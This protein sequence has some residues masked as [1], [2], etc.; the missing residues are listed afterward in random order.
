MRGLNSAL[1]R[2]CLRKNDIFYLFTIMLLGI[3]IRI[4]FIFKVINYP[5]SDFYV[6]Q[7]IA[8]NIFLHKGHTYLGQPIAFQPMGYPTAL[9]Y[10]YRLLGSNN[11]FF[12]KVF[13][14][15]LSILTLIVLLLLLLKLVHTRLSIYLSYIMIIFI[16]NYIAYNNVLGSEILITLLFSI[17]IYLQVCSF[18]ATIR[19]TLI[20]LF[21]GIAALTKPF[22]LVYPFILAV[23]EWLHYKN[24]KNSLKTIS[25]CFI[26]LCLVVSPWTYRNY[27]K[28]KL[29]IPISYNGGY[30]LFINNNENNTSG[31]WMPLSSID[32]SENVKFKFLKVGL[33]YGFPDKNEESQVMLNPHLENIFK[34][35]S[36][37]W[38]LNHPYKFLNLGIIRVHNTFFNG[39]G[40]IYEWAISNN[41]MNTFTKLL[42]SNFFHAFFDNYI[43]VMSFCG[44]IYVLFNFKNIIIAL[45]KKGL[46]VN[47]EISI[48]FLNI[49]FFILII[50]VFEGQPRYNFPIL[51]L[52]AIC[53][54]NY[55]ERIFNFIN[56]LRKENY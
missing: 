6:Y 21:T 43:Y 40:D 26:F 52:F 28:F 3:L 53:T 2:S 24:I 31:A 34:E 35:E 8:T 30:V 22:F 50:F 42:K 38:I 33:K 37:K 54:A 55:M 39:T 4:F 32:V 46:T 18:N 11:I 36:Q 20:G 56:K 16:P 51:F 9:G 41:S 7:N 29:F 49:V 13:N 48:P 15:I 47:Y 1:K 17:I 5:I 14:I 12:G 25:I 19:Y 23:I 44:F 27:K 10:F 45:F